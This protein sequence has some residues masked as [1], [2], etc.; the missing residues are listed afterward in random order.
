[1]DYEL[2]RP[3][4][5]AGAAAK[6]GGNANADLTLAFDVG[7]S[8]IGWAVLKADGPQ[9]LGCGVV[10]FPADDCLASKRRIYRRQ[11]RHVRST[12]QR[13]ERMEKL[14]IHLGIFTAGELKQ[15]HEQG[16]GHPAPCLL[17]A[18]VLASHGA[19]EH[20][21][22]WPQ[23]WD[24][25]RWYAH[26]RGYDGVPIRDPRAQVEFRFLTPATKFLEPTSSAFL[27]SVPVFSEKAV[28]G[29]PGGDVG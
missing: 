3:A 26:N 13:I 22:D 8:S 7:H 9:I 10:T 27:N 17:A 24:V 19:K 11:R 28:F 20:L 25:L 2:K 29:R 15:K 4:P 12:R 5:A 6:H 21:L 14:L 1:M 23:L 16:K 18:R